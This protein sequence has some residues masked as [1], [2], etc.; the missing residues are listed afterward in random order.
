MEKVWGI[1][2]TFDN[3][4]SFKHIQEVDLWKLIDSLGATIFWVMH[5]IDKPWAS[6]ISKEDFI[7]MQ[8]N[9]E[10]LVYSTRKFGVEFSREPSAVEHVE[11]SKSYNAWYNFWHNHF[12]TMDPIVYQNFLND[13]SNGKDIS[14]YL[15][16]GSFKDLLEQP[17]QKKLK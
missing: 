1:Y 16:V 10:F 6:D 8:Y 9:L 5:D 3:P 12:E 7:N 13:K 4:E 11:R 17:V 14:K 2:N 15:P